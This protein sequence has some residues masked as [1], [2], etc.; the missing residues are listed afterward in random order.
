MDFRSS[1][2]MVKFIGI[3]N[4]PMVCLLLLALILVLYSHRG[5]AWK[6]GD[7]G[8]TVEGSSRP[9][10]TVNSMGTSCYRA[11]ELLRGLKQEFSNRVDIWALGCI[12]Y[13]LL[14]RKHAFESDYSTLLYSSGE[15]VLYIPQN[16]VINISE[17]L[18]RDEIK[19]VLEAL[20]DNDPG[21]RPRATVVQ[22]HF[23]VNAPLIQAPGAAGIEEI[24]RSPSPDLKMTNFQAN[25]ESSKKPLLFDIRSWVFR[26]FLFF[27]VVGVVAIQISRSGTPYLPG[28][29]VASDSSIA[30]VTQ[31]LPSLFAL[32]TSSESPLEPVLKPRSPQ[33]AV[34]SP[35]VEKAQ[36]MAPGRTK[37]TVSSYSKKE[38]HKPVWGDIRSGVSYVCVFVIIFL[39]ARIV[40]VIN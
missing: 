3:S 15:R 26:L 13:E 5:F 12:F 29:S 11:P 16:P 8:L 40:L 28:F 17:V 30:E 32:P 39:M 22:D 6:I 38:L 24:H 2:S 36:E 19:I 20:L 10:T 18:S 4:P 37:P 34:S 21:K 31:S 25:E 27:L 35:Q 14:F 7:F 9:R 23:R 33:N 1:M